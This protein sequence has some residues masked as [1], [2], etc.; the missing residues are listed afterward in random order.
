MV[1]LKLE[2][3][4]SAFKKEINIILKT[5]ANNI[6]FKDITI[7][8]VKITK[9]NSYATIYW[10]IYFDNIDIKAVSVALEK[11]KGFCRSALAKT[12]SKYKVP[13]LRFKYDETSTKVKKIDEILSN[14]KKNSNNNE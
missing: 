4:A 11:A 14:I 3:Q 6:L 5:Q 2:Q 1:L 10:T 7:T 9:D 13:I 12:S 8:D